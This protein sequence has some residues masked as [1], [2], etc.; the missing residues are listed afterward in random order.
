MNALSAIEQPSLANAEAEA[1]LCGALMF[2]NRLIDGV[3]DRLKAEDFSDPFAGHLFS[4]IVSERNLGH[5]PNPIT[6]K[7][8]F[9]AEGYRTLCSLTGSDGLASMGARDTAEH[10]RSLAR[11][12]R[13]M[14]GLQEVLTET[15]NAETSLEELLSGAESVVA[16]A[17]DEADEGV[18]ELTGGECI[19]RVLDQMQA[20]EPGVKSGIGSLDHTL[21]PIRKRNLAIVGGRPGMGKSALAISYAI[22]AARNGH[23]VLF[24]SLE[25]SAEEIGERMASDLCFDTNVQ[26]PY[27]AIT[28]GKLS[29][30]QA[31][32]VARSGEFLSTLPLTIVDIGSA[33]LARLGGLVRRHKRRMAAKGHKLE[34]VIVDYLQ[35]VR[36]DHKT[37]GLYEAV[38]EVSRGLKALA[39]THDLGVM[40]LAQL[41]RDVEKRQDKRPMKS[42]LRDSGQIEQDAD[43]ILFLYR[44][45]YYL[46]QQEPENEAERIEWEEAC[47][48]EQG[49][50]DFIVAKRRRGPEGTAVGTFYTA[51]QAVR[52]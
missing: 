32:Q 30:D 41:S 16:D 31:R 11:R 14:E 24:I 5:A 50:L 22:G 15:R 42:D 2:D 40:A 33:S 29:N 49:K 7:P 46:R 4:L 9:D 51:F 39:K 38:T 3:A 48:R 47:Q 52:G 8:F 44:P 28:N 27:S 23:G 37:S 10:I 6:L 18:A 35:L 21:G 36:P 43:A 12:R 13:L 20:N 34:L 19:I 26:V 1:M 17:A 45:E 25:M